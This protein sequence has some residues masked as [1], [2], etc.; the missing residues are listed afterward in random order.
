MLIDLIV[1]LKKK[2]KFTDQPDTQ[3]HAGDVSF[4]RGLAF[5]SVVFYIA[6]FKMSFMTIMSLGIH[7]ASLFL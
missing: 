4:K 6:I 2:Y 7:L 3:L 5:V 1:K